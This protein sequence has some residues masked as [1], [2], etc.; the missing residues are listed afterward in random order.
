MLRNVA[1]PLTLLLGLPVFFF[2]FLKDGP[3]LDKGEQHMV[4]GLY[5]QFCRCLLLGGTL[6]SKQEYETSEEKEGRV[7]CTVLTHDDTTSSSD[8][9][10]PAPY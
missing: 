10:C 9:P 7:D 3:N 6:G 2:F 5:P 4:M 1:A 8:V